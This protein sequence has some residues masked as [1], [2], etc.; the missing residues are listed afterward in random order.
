MANN[1]NNNGNK[2]KNWFGMKRDQFGN[3]WLNRVQPNDIQNNCLRI[4]QDMARGNFDPKNK[5]YKL[6]FKP[7]LGDLPF[8]DL[9][10]DYKYLVS[11]PNIR[12][13]LKNS[14]Y[15]IGNKF[16]FGY[17]ITTHMSQGSEF[18]NGIYFEEYLR[19]DINNKLNYVGLSRFRNFCI[20]VK[21]RPKKYY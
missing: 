19:P 11:P 3:D 18:N 6:N 12:N 1:N 20:Y 5:A 8:N 9:A 21:P 15:S 10:C 13:D 2:R 17:A 4:I 16:E 7:D 14:P